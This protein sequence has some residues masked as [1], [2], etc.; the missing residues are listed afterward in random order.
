M[1]G[2][3]YQRVGKIAADVRPDVSAEW[4]VEPNYISFASL[5]KW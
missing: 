3:F 1:E 4:W 5:L 2:S